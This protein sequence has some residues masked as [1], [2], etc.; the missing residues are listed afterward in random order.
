M[1]LVARDLSKAMHAPSPASQAQ[2]V[3]TV[4]I[5]P[6]IGAARRRPAYDSGL[7]RV[8]DVLLVV[9]TAPVWV[10]F[11]LLTAA[12]VACDGHAPFYR[13]ERVGRNGR[14]FRIWKL[15]TMVPD[16]DA[17][18]KT[19]LAANPRARAEWEASQKLKHD[20]RITTVGRILRKTSLD[21]LPQLLNVLQGDMS[22]V[23]PRPMMVSQVHLYHGEAYYRLRPGLT[24]L[25]QVSGRNEC[26]FVDRVRF[27]EAYGRSMS[28]LTDL[29][30][31]TRTVGV[32]LRGTGY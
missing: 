28:F 3:S 1:T 8:L 18:L 25:W 9:L 14:V 15:R 21:E 16:A 13:Q 27:D 5:E 10:S 11:I 19:Y 2:S 12:V 6:R 29:S 7:K 17:R 22:L 24:G 20:P 4:T 30:I 32:V 31:M 23:G 26:R